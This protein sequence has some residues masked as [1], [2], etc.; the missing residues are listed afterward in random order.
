M[1][2]GDLYDLTWVS[3]PRLSPDGRTAAAGGVR[4]ARGGGGGGGGAAP[5]P[6]R[7]RAGA[8]VVAGRHPDRLPLPRA[9]PGVRARGGREAPRAPTVHAPPVQERPVRLDRRP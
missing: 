4:L 6:R 9:R 5:R 8:G 3:D 7:G 2:P 1:R